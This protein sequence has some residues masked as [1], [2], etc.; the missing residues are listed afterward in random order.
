MAQFRRLGRRGERYA[1][2]FISALIESEPT[3]SLD[4][5]HAL[6]I[7]PTQQLYAL[8]STYPRLNFVLKQ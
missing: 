6:Q 8:G 4:L 2:L 7:W 5:Y 3:I 1:K